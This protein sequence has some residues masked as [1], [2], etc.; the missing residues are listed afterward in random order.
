MKN[1]I[2]T[3]YTLDQIGELNDSY[4]CE[5]S[6]SMIMTAIDIMNADLP[7]KFI[8]CNGS[9]VDISKF[10]IIEFEECEEQVQ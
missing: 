3:F 7:H 1:F 4:Q 9:I 5:I 10:A 2:A 6:E 8:Q